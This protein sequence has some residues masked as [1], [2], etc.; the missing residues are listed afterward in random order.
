MRKNVFSKMGALALI[1]SAALLMP[2]CGNV[3]NPLEEI[4]SGGSGSGSG[5]S[6]S[7]TSKTA[8]TIKYA[9]ATLERGTADP[10]FTYDLANSGDGAVVYE[11]SDPT[12]AEVNATT[13]EVTPKAVG[14]VTIKAT[15]SD[16]ESYTYATKT[17]SYDLTLQSG[18][19]YVDG[20]NTKFLTSTSEYTEVTSTT[21]DMT[22]P[23]KKYL[24]NGKVTITGDV[25]VYTYPG[26]GSPSL[27]E[28]LLCDGAELIVTGKISG[29]YL[30]IYAQSNGA[31][32]GKLTVTSSDANAI[33]ISTG[34][35]Y[36]CGGK[37]TATSTKA[38][39][40]GIYASALYVNGGEVKAQGGAGGHGVQYLGGCIYL[41][42]GKL[43]AIG[44]DNAGGTGGHGVNSTGGAPVHIQNNNAVL[45]A[46][47]GSG[48]TGGNGVDVS[49]YASNSLYYKLGQ[50]TAIGGTG[51]T[52]ANNGQGIKGKLENQS[53]AAVTFQASTDGTDWPE[54]MYFSLAH[55]ATSTPTALGV[56][57]VD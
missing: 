21:T 47:G 30:N 32:M 27:T 34:S 9:S 12:I 17:A 33:D 5:G 44:G 29:Q 49:D 42:N 40:H 2:S 14:T 24:V 8:A 19:S 51:T 20:L 3:D 43:E 35:L 57:K 1:L 38:G 50:F 15:V 22:T 37:I 56:R 45:I 26:E 46:R 36:F 31:N 18:I 28:I 11:S 52:T 16:S 41:N 4:A 55:S 48:A 23:G 39:G 25:S 13:G 7:S 54:D 6:S 53:G 10:A